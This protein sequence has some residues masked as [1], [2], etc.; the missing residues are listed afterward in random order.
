MY[1]FL[2]IFI[3]PPP[4]PQKKKKKKKKKIIVEFF[5]S[6]FWFSILIVLTFSEQ[7]AYTVQ[8]KRNAWAI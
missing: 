2:P 5:D 4:P 8:A 3:F 7:V 1:F 6:V